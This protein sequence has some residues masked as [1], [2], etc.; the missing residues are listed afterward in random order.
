[1]FFQGNSLTVVAL[2]AQLSQGLM[3]MS[4]PFAEPDIFR[5]RIDQLE[6]ALEGIAACA[7]HCPCCEMHRQIAVKA[8]GYNVEITME[9]V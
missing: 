6:R 1:M 7:T 9:V 5:K 8:L 2:A 3:T 4:N